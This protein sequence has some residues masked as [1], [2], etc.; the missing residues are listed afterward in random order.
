MH[1]E[2]QKQWLTLFLI[3]GI[4][5]TTFIKL[6]ARFGSPLEVLSASEK[7]L[8]EVVGKALAHRIVHYREVVDVDTELKLIEKHKVKIITLDDPEYPFSLAEIYEPPLVLYCKGNLLK[9]DQYSIS[10]VGTR[11]YSPYGSRVTHFFARGLA[12]AGFTVVSGLAAGIDTIAHQSALDSGGRTVA[13]LGCGVDVIYPKENKELYERIQNQGAV[14]STFPMQTKPLGTNFPVRNRFISGF[15][16]GTIVTE[17]TRN[18]GA[19]I[20][21]QHAVE[22]GKTIFAVPGP[23]GSPNSEGP[24]WLIRQGAKLA[25]KISDIIEEIPQ[26]ARELLKEEMSNIDSE[27]QLNSVNTKQSE[28]QLPLAMSIKPPVSV[29]PIQSEI[30]NKKEIVSQKI[31][32]IIDSSQSPL[33]RKILSILSPEGSYVDEVALSCQIPVS[34][35]LSTLTLMEIKGWV[36]QFSGKRFTKA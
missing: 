25:E 9:R 11:K 29:V 16:L 28:I 21:A 34:E 15:S 18:S 14:I 10:I 22:Q 5:S 7:S 33:E 26:Y 32:P 23:I 19:L 8:S 30:Q 2:Q 35:A 31:T 20:T 3:P 4:G 27:S 6:I 12:N 13:F 17:A 1:S 36:K 24:H